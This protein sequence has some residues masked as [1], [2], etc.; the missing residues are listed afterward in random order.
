MFKQGYGLTE[1]GVN[2][3]SMTV[4]ESVRKRGSIGK[5]LMMTEARLVDE[6]GAGGRRWAR[7]ANCG[8]AGRT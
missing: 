8:C 4:E 2:C 7:W 1:V 6:Q 5:P 3:F